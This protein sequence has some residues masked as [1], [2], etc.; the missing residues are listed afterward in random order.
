[1]NL[2]KTPYFTANLLNPT[3][4]IQRDYAPLD[5]FVAYMCVA[6]E[7]T[8]EAL[9]SEAEE[10]AVPLRIGEAVLI[11]ATLNDVVIT[12]KGECKLLEIYLE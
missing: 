3:Q 10:K 7:C 12:P 11:P 1:M 4:P 9:D 5:S 6:G 2:Q 8:V